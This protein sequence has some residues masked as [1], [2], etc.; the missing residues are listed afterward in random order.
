LL[1][2]AAKY[3]QRGGR[4]LLEAKRENGHALLR[5]TDDGVGIRPEM[6][7]SVF[8]LFVQSSATLDRSEGGMGVGL[9]LV[10][11]LVT[12]HGGTV[13][14]RSEGEGRGSEFVVRLPVT[15]QTPEEL[16]RGRQRVQWPRGTKILVVEDNADSRQTLCTLLELAGFSCHSAENGAEGLELLKLHRPD[17]AIIDIGLPGIDGFELARRIRALPDAE[18]LYLVALTGYGQP[19]DR[20]LA[21]EAGFDEHLVKPLHPEDLSRLLTRGAELERAADGGGRSPVGEA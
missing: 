4:V 3:T 21:L 16:P 11:S 10:R 12:M 14:A 17:I 19:S 7:D 9:T 1:S 13:S 15:A 5:V 18:Q 20:A 6:L 2:N 8:D